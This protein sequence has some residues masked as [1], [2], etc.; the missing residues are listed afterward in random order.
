MKGKRYLFLSPLLVLLSIGLLWENQAVSAGVRA[1]LVACANVII[2]SL[3]PFMILANIIAFS[4]SGAYLNKSVAGFTRKVLGLPEHLGCVVLMNFIGG[5]PVGAR[6]IASKVKNREISPQEASRALCFCVNAGPSYLISAVGAGMLSSRSAGLSLYFSQI[7]S[8]LAIGVIVFRRKRDL[9]SQRQRGSDILYGKDVF[10]SSVTAASAAI[11]STCAFVV[12][13]SAI[14]AFLSAIG[15]TGLF[16]DILTAILPLQNKDFYIAAFTG[17]IEV[18]S[19]CAAASGL[20]TQGGVLLLGFLVSFSSLSI[21]FQIKSAFAG[22]SQINFVPFY[23]SRMVH[24]GLT[25]F[26]FGISLRFLPPADLMVF[27][28]GQALPAAQITPQMMISSVCL[29]CMCSILVFT[30]ARKNC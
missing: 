28:G 30:A 27:S 23:L 26:L 29:M 13:F 19:G 18:T 17:I 25:C 12:A 4:R 16:A 15:I 24:G 5:Y 3:F 6:M 8:A 7:L 9:C 2:P 20:H 10:V 22:L 1:G 21:I 11:L 14:I